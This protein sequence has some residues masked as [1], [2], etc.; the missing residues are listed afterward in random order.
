ME[1]ENKEANKKSKTK[2]NKVNS[3]KEK[4]NRNELFWYQ[5]LGYKNNPLSIKPT[6]NNNLIGYEKIIQRIIYQC[7]I[8]NVIFLEGS[9]GTGKSSI[10][11]SIYNKLKRNNQVLYFNYA[12]NYNLKKGIMYKRTIIQKLFFLKPK[13][14]IVFIDEANLADKKDFDFLYEFYIMDR[15][16]SIVFAGTDFKNVPFNKAFKSDTKQYKLDEIKDNL[17]KEI[18]DTRMPGQ[19]LLSPAMAKKIFMNSDNNPRQFLENVEDIF[20]LVVIVG[21]SKITKNDVE[22]FFLRYKKRVR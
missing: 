6:E 3:N 10:L 15:V 2:Q 14:M 4:N 9:Y 8:G 22:K 21:K 19:K 18:I 5:S 11:K 20:R 7:K 12:R 16:K 17:S 13:K 1:K